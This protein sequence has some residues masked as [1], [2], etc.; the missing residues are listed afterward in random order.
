MNAPLTT[1]QCMVG[2]TRPNAFDALRVAGK[3]GDRE[4]NLRLWRTGDALR[5]LHAVGWQAP[6]GDVTALQ[7]PEARAAREKFAEIEAASDPVVWPLVVRVVIE[8]AAIRECRDM[9]I[10]P[11]RTGMVGY[12]DA[13]LLDQ[14]RA[15]LDRI[16]PAF[17]VTPST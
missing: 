4:T 13:V 8:G 16:A 6:S 10:L 12:A 3:L 7:T 11:V 2:R 17:G 14:L 1:E 15:A 9:L 5:R